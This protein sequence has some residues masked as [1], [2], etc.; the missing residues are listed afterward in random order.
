MRNRQNITKIISIIAI[1]LFALF[2]ISCGGGGG[3]D[4]GATSEISYT[5]STEPATISGNN[6]TDLAT[7]SYTNGKLGSA[8]SNIAASQT[9]S[10]EQNY[11]PPMLS[12]SNVLKESLYK[13]D[14]TSRSSGTF[15][16]AVYQKTDSVIGSCGG[17]ASYTISVNDQTG[18]FSGNFNYNQYCGNGV[19]IS[20]SVDFSG[21]VDV[22]TEEILTFTFSFNNLSS[23]QGSDSVTIKGD[24]SFDA[25]GSPVVLTMTIWI[26]DSR[27][28][29]VYWVKDYRLE[30]TEGVGYVD[31]DI[32]GRFYHPDHGYVTLSTEEMLRLYDGDEYPS[33]GVLVVTGGGNTRARLE[34]ISSTTYQ[35]LADTDGDGLYDDYDS[36]VSNWADL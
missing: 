29:R 18:E 31:I 13:A 7:E 26:K 20:G 4:D 33:S 8:M 36:G 11:P 9:E 34:Y 23:T 21:Q 12:V 22:N 25:T 17:S 10:S 19:I 3:G 32:S 5:G 6:A 15:A 24:I 16:G 27:I 30:L 2:L 28:N 14:L 1:L 35:V